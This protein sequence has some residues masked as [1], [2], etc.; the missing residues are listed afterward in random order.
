KAVQ[1]A[2]ALEIRDRGGGH[3]SACLETLKCTARAWHLADVGDAHSHT[4]LFADLAG[5]TALSEAHGDREAANVAA[6]FATAVRPLLPSRRAQ[7]IKTIGDA[8]MIR[9]S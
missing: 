3:Q 5:F 1:E 2:L 9:G 7:E 4:F 8:L 6:E